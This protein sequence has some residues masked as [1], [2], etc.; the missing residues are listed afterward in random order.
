MYLDLYLIE[1]HIEDMLQESSSLHSSKQPQS[2]NSPKC[3]SIKQINY[4]I[5]IH[6]NAKQ[7]DNRGT[8]DLC[9]G[10]TESPKHLNDEPKEVK[11][12]VYLP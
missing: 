1:T 3:P 11:H 12:R 6:W 10:T 8:T 5:F 4:S 9:Y 7:N 2:G